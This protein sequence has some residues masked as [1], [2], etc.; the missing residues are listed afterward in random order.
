MTNGVPGQ[1]PQ[2]SKHSSSL[3]T[4]PPTSN[5]SPNAKAKRRMRNFLLQPLLQ[6]KLG[7]YAILLSVVFAVALSAILY[8]NFAGLVNSIVLL[9]DAEDEVRELFMDYWKG[10]QLWVYLCFF[11]YLAGTVLLSV[12]YMHKLVGPTIAFR[13]HIR[14]LADG[15]YN[16]RTY[17]RKGDAFLEVADELNRLSEVMEKTK[18]QP[19]NLPK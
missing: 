14:S 11:I 4:Q 10:T 12:L 16:A 15:R 8:H 19:H 3:Q 17:L 6:V 2:S 18:G 7:L 5:S 9:T 1:A 13:R